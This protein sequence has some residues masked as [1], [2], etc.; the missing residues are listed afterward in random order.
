MRNRRNITHHLYMIPTVLILLFCIVSF[1]L[2]MGHNFFMSIL[3]F[4]G[5]LLS[6]AAVGLGLGCL[7]IMGAWLV[8]KLSEWADKKDAQV[9]DMRSR[10]KK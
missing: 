2:T 5:I 1:S 9:V 8:I 4:L 10:I 7:V 6:I 3:I